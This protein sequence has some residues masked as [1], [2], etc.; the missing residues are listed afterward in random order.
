[1]K[2]IIYICGIVALLLV[3]ILNLVFTAKLD[4]SEHIT[5]TYNTFLYIIGVV[6]LAV[7][8]FV[9]ARLANKYLYKDENSKTLKKLRKILFVISVFLFC[10]FNIVWVIVV[11]PAIVGDQIHAC[12]LAQTFYNNNLEEFLPQLTYAGIPLSEYM[13][14]YHQQISLAFVF[15]LFF[16]IIHFDGIGILRVLNVIGNI[17][18]VFALYKI[19]CQLNKKYKTNKVLLMVLILTFFSLSMLSTFIYGDIPSLALCLFS[20]YFVMKFVESKK[21]K[22]AIFASICTMFAYMFR[23]NSLIF[24]IATIIYLA[25][26]LFK[27]I[28][29]KPWKESVINVAVIIMYLVVSIVPT[30]IV[31]NYYLEKYNMDKNKEYPN[32][33]YILMAMTESWRGYGWY[34]E[35]IGEPALR[36]SEGKKIEYREEITERLKYFVQNPIEAF[37]FYTNKLASMWTENTYAAV[38]SNLVKEND[39]LENVYEP[40]E[41]YQKALLLVSCTC[42]LVVLIQNRKNMSLEL[43]FLITIFIG[44]FAFHI[45]WE[46]KSRYII[47]YIVALIPVA[48]IELKKCNVK[49]LT[50]FKEGKWFTQ[51]KLKQ[52]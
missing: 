9:L 12:N 42:S 36:D 19:T 30:I 45:L 27:E 46:A 5:I 49:K 37:K 23:M 10:A 13:Q 31:Q 33:S 20:V 1:M 38:R 21:I 47:P 15:S 39:P 6:L 44:G 28:T 51:K 35:D 22:Y 32:E 8:I 40:L 43:I 26:N 2:K 41:F 7:L 52:E 29:K 16:R 24:I 18:I 3:I 17:A 14:A 4:N 11:R 34:N 48:A 50:N 25:L